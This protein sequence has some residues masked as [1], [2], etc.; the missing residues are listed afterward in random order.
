VVGLLGVKEGGV[1]A[2]AIDTH[3]EPTAAQPSRSDEA[4]SGAVRD[5]FVGGDSG[6]QAEAGGAD[7][8]QVGGRWTA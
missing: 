2:G 1:G 3:A 5:W 6:A 4:L 8:A 7:P